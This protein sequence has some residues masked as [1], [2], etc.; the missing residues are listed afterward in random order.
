MYEL[1]KVAVQFLGVGQGLF[2]LF[3]ENAG[4]TLLSK[5]K[6]LLLCGGGGTQKLEVQQLNLFCLCSHATTTRPA[7]PWEL[8]PGR[9]VS[10]EGSHIT[11][12]ATFPFLME[13]E[14]MC[15]GEWQE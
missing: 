15:V 14:K 4:K 10:R 12:V 13:N 9:R 7:N 11:G 1:V 2:W 5:K 3:L 6:G 8:W